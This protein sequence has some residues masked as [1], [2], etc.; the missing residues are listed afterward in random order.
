MAFVSA[1]WDSFLLA[2]KSR[3][4]NLSSQG[5]AGQGL[6]N[7]RLQ[8]PTDTPLALE[9]KRTALPNPPKQRSGPWRS[10]LRHPEPDRLPPNQNV[11]E[12]SPVPG[13]YLATLWQRRAWSPVRRRSL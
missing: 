8:N 6:G 2:P 4:R 12:K 7:F 13:R 1:R 9:T 11:I 5:T 3:R 10:S